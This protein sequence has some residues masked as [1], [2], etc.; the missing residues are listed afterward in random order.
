M[1]N[2]SVSLPGYTL[3]E[4]LV[5]V[6]IVSIAS[7]IVISNFSASRVKE[8]TNASVREVMAV[9]RQAQNDALTGRQYVAN[10]KPCRF[11]VSWAGSTYTYTFWYLD[12]FGLCN[13]S[14]SVKSYTLKNSAA[15]SGVGSL[16]FSPPHGTVNP[17]VTNT[18]EI[19]NSGSSRVVCVSATGLVTSAVGSTCP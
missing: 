19:T 14:L 7:A 6:A 11:Q 17:A 13:T 12:S 8:D 9:M 5:V 3:L 10:A 15:F 18:I 4:L 1:K 2:V 16:S